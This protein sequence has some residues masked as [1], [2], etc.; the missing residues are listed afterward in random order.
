MR[1]KLTPK[2]IDKAA[3]LHGAE[4]TTFWDTALPGFG[5]MVTSRGHRSYVCQYRAGRISRRLTL[6]AGLSLTEAKREAKAILGAVAKGRDPLQEKRAKVSVQAN[7]L[8]SVAEEYLKRE[9]K[10]LRNS[11]LRDKHADFRLY[12]FP[13][14]GARPIDGIRRSEVVN[15]LDKVEDEAGP[16][17][18]QHAFA[19]LRRLM[20]WHASRSDEFRSPIVRGMSRVQPKEIARSRVLTDDELRAVWQAAE[21]TP[22]AAYGHLVKFI[23]LTATR[24]KEA[25]DMTRGELNADGTE[26]LIPAARYKGKHDHLIPL[27]GTAQMVFAA[28]P[29]IGSRGWVFTS[30]GQV[31]I[32]GFAKFKRRFDIQVLEELRKHDADAKL[33][34]WTT[35]DLRRTARSLMSRAAISADHAERALGHVIAGVRG[36]YDRHEFK[37]EKRHAFEALAGEVARIINPP[38]PSVVPLRRG[39]P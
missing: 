10:G 27:S 5:L 17:A 20:N 7:S 15:L 36:V 29:K 12:I 19:T 22:A 26:W 1:Q 16:V 34:R 2:F 23:L 37:E 4:R 32:S 31:P 9:G 38:H 13:R 6:K 3:A 18:A 11:T 28:I 25:A 30:N 14:F 8:K 24:L 35:H 39:K 21:A 33:P